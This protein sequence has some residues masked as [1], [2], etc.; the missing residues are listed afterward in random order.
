MNPLALAQEVINAELIAVHSMLKRMGQEFDAVIDCFL[1][2]QGRIVVLGM[3]KSGIVGQ[4]I[5]ATLASTGTPSFFVHP[6]EAFHGDLGMIKPNDAVI[7]ISNSGETEELIRLIPFFLHQGNILIALTGAVDSSLG[8]NAHH[9]LDIGVEKEACTNNLAPTSST[10]CTLVMGDAIAV[11]LSKIKNFQPEDFARFHPGGSLGRKLLTNVKD[12]M[13]KHN[14]PMCS[15]T[16]SFKDVIKVI[17]KGRRGVA[18]I[19]SGDSL[20]GVITDGDVRRALDKYENPFNLDVV[21]IMSVNPITINENEKFSLAE[22]KMHDSK[23]NMLVV[24]NEKKQVSGI[25]QIFDI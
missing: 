2:V 13:H 8:R 11:A 17:S 3:G 6:G 25:I 10:T 15:D 1:K 19:M 20:K 4:K 12:V 9:I 16:V 21:E 24:L 5:S 18:L 22:K 23:V 7:M 14:L